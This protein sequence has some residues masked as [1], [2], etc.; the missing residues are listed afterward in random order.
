MLALRDD[1]LAGRLTLDEFSERV[2][3]AYRARMGQDL[4]R[5]RQDLP[6]SG[7]TG[8]GSD[9]RQ[10]RLTVAF[11]GRVIRRG[12]LRL[13][14]RTLVVSTFGDVDFDLREAE[15]HDSRVVVRLIVFFG[16]VDL[17]VPEGINVEVDGAVV[18]GR[19]RDWG[20]DVVRID[21]PTISVRSFGCFGTV[22]VWRVPHEMRGT[23]SE[24]FAQIEAQQW[25]LPA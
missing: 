25:Q 18:F 9:R 24:I 3:I 11:F 7:S 12:R 1:L 19:S 15:L 10:K 4:V 20:R 6:D 2:E 22:D 17:Y 5:V 21:A 8:I 13:R 16:D 23:Y 14:R